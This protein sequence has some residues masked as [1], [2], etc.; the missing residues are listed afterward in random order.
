MSERL[1]LVLL[2][3]VAAMLAA[4]FFNW[5]RQPPI[6]AFTPMPADGSA[7]ALPAPV[8]VGPGRFSIGN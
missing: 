4:D 8:Q 7:P 5:I 1:Q 2:A 6:E 3:L